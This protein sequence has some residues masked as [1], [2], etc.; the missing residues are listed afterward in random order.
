MGDGNDRKCE[1]KKAPGFVGAKKTG[2]GSFVVIARTEGDDTDYI[3]YQ[4]R[5]GEVARKKKGCVK[6]GSAG[7]SGEGN[8]RS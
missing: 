8:R 6:D 7:T 1:K 3:M 2:V 5:V 4:C